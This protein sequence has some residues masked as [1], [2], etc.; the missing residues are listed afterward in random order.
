MV[1]GAAETVT[2]QR[3]SVASPSKR[4]GMFFVMGA[5][6]AE[7]RLHEKGAGGWILSLR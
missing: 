3:R 2:E 1:C 7:K 4:A 6:I 5:N